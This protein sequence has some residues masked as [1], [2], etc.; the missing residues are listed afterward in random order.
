MPM[1]SWQGEMAQQ[2]ELPA[3]PSWTVRTASVGVQKDGLEVQQQDVQG[4]PISPNT[5]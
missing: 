5:S 4:I 2:E 1:C 3:E